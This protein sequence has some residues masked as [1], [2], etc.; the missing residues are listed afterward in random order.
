V[1]F[2]TVSA[3]EQASI[4]ASG[5]QR[6]ASPWELRVSGRLV[7]GTEAGGREVQSG[8]RPCPRPGAAQCPL[9]R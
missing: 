6:P 3:A 1:A 7:P 5:N 2:F 9:P 8:G 4:A